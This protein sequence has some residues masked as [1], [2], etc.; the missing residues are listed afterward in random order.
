MDL[1]A[2]VPIEFHQRL[3][4]HES[5]AITLR[6]RRNNAL[7]RMTGGLTVA[8]TTLVGGMYLFFLLVN[9]I[10]PL[11]IVLALPL[12][13]LGATVI[14]AATCA[15]TWRFIEPDARKLLA[16]ISEEDAADFLDD[17]WQRRT[18]LLTE[19]AAFDETLEAFKALPERAGQD[20]IDAG[21]LASLAERRARLEAE[22]AKYLSDF[23]AAT[24]EERKR[25][26]LANV[27]RKRPVSPHRLSLR[28]YKRKRKLLLRLERSLDAL[29][30]SASGSTTADLSPYQA[31]L[32][33]RAEL[34][35]ERVSLIRCGFRP[36][37]LPEPRPARKLL[38][39]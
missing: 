18:R 27:P 23:D 35:E 20:E 12:F 29:P 22:I 5:Q 14:A 15:A 1:T 8:G 38:K 37:K 25:V 33:F 16:A 7:L 39:P 17:H 24:V 36:R 2:L 32:R 19:A 9:L 31:A 11:P 13:L 34:E 26:A 21:V 28:E 10:M 30:G 6:K 4:E 3:Y